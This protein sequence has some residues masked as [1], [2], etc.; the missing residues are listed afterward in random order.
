VRRAPL[1]IAALFGLS[2]AGLM[3]AIRLAPNDPA[4]WH[5]DPLTAD[6]TGYPNE[7]RV[8]PDGSA[9]SGAH[10]TAPVYPVSVQTLAVAFD[11]VALAAPR[12]RRIAGSPRDLWM[13][14]V[15]RSR[16]MGFPDYISVRAIPEGENRATLA[17]FSRS[18]FG[19]SDLGMN[20]RRV[21]DWLAALQRRIWR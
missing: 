10:E 7:F 18:R 8:L 21:Q 17:I 15:Q 20:A 9:F 5:A 19:R 12:T 2:V 14:Y 11:A 3:A 4:V 16:V 1:L 6:S 13:T